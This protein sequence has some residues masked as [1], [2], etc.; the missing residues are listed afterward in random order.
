MNF[1]DLHKLIQNGEDATVE[2]K[3]EVSQD[4]LQGLSTDLAALANAHGGLIIFGVTKAKDPAGCSIQG[5]EK[6]QISQQARNCQPPVEINFEQVAFGQRQ[7]L[8]V[9]VS[10]GRVVHSDLE[11]RFPVRIGDTTGYLDILGILTVLQQRGFIPAEQATFVSSTGE[12]RRTELPQAERLALLD[13]LRSSDPLI[14]T[15]GVR[16]LSLM[17]HRFEVLTDDEIAVTIRSLL[18]SKE[19]AEDV[20]RGLLFALNGLQGWGVDAERSQIEAFVPVFADLATGSTSVETARAAFVL[21]VS[22][23]SAEAIRVISE[24]VTQSS[25]ERYKILQPASILSNVRYYG[26]DSGLRRAMYKV[27]Q[28]PFSEEI[29]RRASVILESVRQSG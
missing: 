4:V 2:F 19:I 21:L 15:E 14:V 1:D 28:A 24:W 16:D 23:R 27:L 26:L 10:Q 13:H 20:R 12:F 3:Q 5:K 6:E 22:L 9:K 29:K 25:D 7:F 18:K 8:L 17:A 11:R